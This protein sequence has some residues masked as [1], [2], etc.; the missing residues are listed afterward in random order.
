ME[1]FYQFNELTNYPVIIAQLNVSLCSSCISSCK[2]LYQIK[3]ATSLWLASFCW[4]TFIV[5][6]SPLCLVFQNKLF[7]GFPM[8]YGAGIVLNPVIACSKRMCDHALWARAFWMSASL[9]WVL[10][11]SLMPLSWSVPPGAFDTTKQAQ[12]KFAAAQ[13]KMERSMLNITYEH[14]K[15]NIWVRGMRSGFK[16]HTSSPIFLTHYC[17]RLT[18]FTFNKS[19]EYN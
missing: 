8:L 11:E 13:T 18:T 10:R 9:A 6:K 17:L 16:P 3:L 15:T 1:P 2:S 5:V 7:F 4:I 12:N 14:R 19:R